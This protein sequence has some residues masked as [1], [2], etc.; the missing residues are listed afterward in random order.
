VGL[1][2]KDVE[3]TIR[4]F[5]ALM[6]GISPS[7]KTGIEGLKMG[8]VKSHFELP[9]LEREVADSIQAAIARL[10]DAGAIIIEVDDRAFQEL[11]ATF[12]DILLFEA[13]EIHGKQVKS[14]PTH[15]GPETL[16]LLVAAEA[17][18]ID[19]YEKAIAHRS[20]LLPAAQKVYADIDVLLTPTA[21]FVAPATTPPVDTPEGAVEGFYTGIFN[22]TGD[23]AIS[24]PCGLN[25]EGL[26]IGLQL[27]SVKGTDMRLLSIAQAIEELLG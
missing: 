20:E 21:P 27:A 23:P 17:V 9:E 7:P 13:W 12:E 5:A 2:A 6:G 26:P 16:R 1:L 18:T 22:I 15:F 4:I 25:S 14:D 3:T 8:I 19:A 11:G 24:I 10:K